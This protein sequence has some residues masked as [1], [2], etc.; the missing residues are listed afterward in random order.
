MNPV[1]KALW[2]VESHSRMPITLEQVAIASDVSPYYLTRAFSTIFGISLMRYVRQRRLSEAA[3]QLAFGVADILSLALD[4][5]YGSHEAF[6]RAFKQEFQL[7]PG[8]VRSQGHVNN[9]TLTKAFAMTT[10][11]TPKLQKPRIESLSQKRMIGILDRYD[12]KSPAGIPDQ[13]QRFQQYLGDISGQVGQDA[14]GI[15]FNFDED[16]KFDYLTGVETSEKGI[17]PFGLL[18]M[19]LPSQKY[20]VFAHGGHIAEIRAV[21]AAIWSAGLPESG[22]EAA[23]GPTLEKYGSGFDPETGLGGYEIWVAVK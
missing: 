10:T 21:I 5:G 2:Y 22:L 13:W 7:T 11:P 18:Y 1:Q 6:S 12:C 20:A 15:C 16:S 9:L 14:Y 19:N 4:H 23:Q 17:V 3:K 8:Y